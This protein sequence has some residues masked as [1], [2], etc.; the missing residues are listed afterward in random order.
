MQYVLVAAALLPAIILLTFIYKKDKYDKEPP[1]LLF[2]LLFSGA[3]VAV[4]AIPVEG[5]VLGLIDK[6]F[7][8]AV[9]EQDGVNYFRSDTLYYAYQILRNFIGVALVEEGLKWVVLVLI[10]RKNRHFN[11][12]F[13]GVIYAVFV[14]LGFAAL[15]NVLYVFN[16]GLGVAVTR[17]VLSVP[18]HMFNAVFMGFFYSTW[19][20]LSVAGKMEGTLM[21]DGILPRIASRFRPG[22]YLAF[23][24]VVPTLVH[25]F[26]D[27]CLSL[28][29]ALFTVIFFI[30]VISLYVYC[31]R[32]ISRISKSDNSDSILALGMLYIAYPGIG[33]D[34]RTVP[35]LLQGGLLPVS[36]DRSGTA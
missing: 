34:P 14:S 26:Y 3:A 20:I 7:A 33:F 24:L 17:A 18:G 22:K 35:C 28:E 6:G 31:F 5:F 30:F 8:F 27:Y 25:G 36:A 9:V 23:S 29:S 4:L 10:T 16:L 2:G 19:H 32:K 11:S 21:R 15:E 12:Y 13:D 1:G